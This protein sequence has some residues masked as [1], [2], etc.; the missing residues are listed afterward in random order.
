MIKDFRVR[1]ERR[2]PDAHRPNEI[3]VVLSLGIGGRP[4]KRINP[5]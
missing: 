2:V 1:H 5:Y 3:P 4:L